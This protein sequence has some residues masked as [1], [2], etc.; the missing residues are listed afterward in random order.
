VG[1]GFPCDRR[2]AFARRSCDKQKLERDDE[3]IAL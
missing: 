3:V 1:T 2:E